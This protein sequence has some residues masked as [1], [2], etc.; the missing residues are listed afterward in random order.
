[1]R[2]PG[3]PMWLIHNP[4]DG[5][6]IDVVKMT[7]VLS[8]PASFATTPL[9][10]PAAYDFDRQFLAPKNPDSTDIQQD[11]D[12]DG[13][14]TNSS[15]NIDDRIL[16]ASEDNNIIVA[17]HS[18]QVGSAFLQSATV[19]APSMSNPNP[20][21]SGYTVGDTL[22]LVGGT[23]TTA[24]QLTVATLGPGGS[25]ATVTIANP[26]NYT[27][28]PNG[29]VTGGT[30][31][32]ATFSL[33]FKGELDVQ[34]YAID[35]SGA[36]PA[37]QL[38]GGVANVGRI[39]FGTNTYSFYPGIDINSSGQIGLSFMESDTVGGAVN[40]ATSG[41]VS[42]FVTAR[43]PGDAA[44][45]TEASVLVPAGT[46]SGDIV[47]RAGDFSGMNVDP[48]NGTFWGT[49]QFGIGS[50][51]DNVIANFTPDAT[52][53][54]TPP[55]PQT[56][57]EGASQS[58]SLGSFIDPNT[59]PWSVDVSWGDGTPDTVFTATAPGTIS[60]QSHTYGEEGP[61]TGTITVTNT[62]I[63]LFDSQPFTVTVTDPPVVQAS[64]VPVSAV[65]GASFGPVALAT[66]TDPGG[67][68]P[69]PSDPSGTL[70][71]HYS[72]VS[73]DWGDGTPLDTSSGS[74]S[75]SGSPG[76]TTDPFTVSGSHTYGEEGPY[77]VTVIVDHEGVDTT[78]TDT[79]SVSDPAVVATG[80]PV[81]ATACTA[82]TAVPI[83]TFIDPGGAEPNPS[84]PTPG[85]SNH[86][87]VDSIDWGD[88]TPLDTSSGSISYSGSPGSTTDPFTVSGSHTYET[89]G[90]FTITAIIDHEG[91]LTTVTTTAIVKDKLGL[92]LLDP[93]GSKSLMVSG[94]GNVDVTGDCGAVVVD[95]NNP[96][97]AVLVSGNGV[98]AAGDFDVTGGVSTS[99]H[100]VVPSP[101]D[102]EAPTAD[103]LGLVLPSPP[104]PTFG[105][106]HISGGTVTLPAGTYV[107]GISVSGNSTVTLSAGVYYMEGGGF[108]VSGGSVVTGTSGVVIINAPGRPSDSISVSGKGVLDLTAPGSGQPFQGVALFQDPSSSITISFT[109]QANVTITGVV[110]APAA[111]VSITGNA[112]VTINPGAGTA[113]LPPIFAAMIA[114]D[115]QVTGNGDL[116]I[117]ADDPPGQPAIALL[118]GSGPAGNIDAALANLGSGT[119]LNNAVFIDPLLI[120]NVASDL[121][122]DS[123]WSTLFPSTKRSKR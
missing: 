60:S 114:Y 118:Q 94:N 40:A 58:F 98:V 48:V 111:P 102:H 44:G 105:A 108:S 78:L 29:T 91:V 73:I 59:G 76:S 55:G 62:F 69:N 42:T 95:S 88:A 35:V 106:K 92:L 7:S 101:I 53:T 14:T 39:G 56:S 27:G 52:P 86:Y 117:N 68:E 25:V 113:T 82:L 31:T 41:F 87:K 110:Y 104:S 93:T 121:Q 70:N 77:T 33:D 103:P 9:T 50:T 13:D 90:T 34:W 51:P 11:D 43:E 61:Y 79:A 96:T 64:S 84:D 26:G 120:N 66:F 99:G 19:P 2:R 63:G 32:G 49:N 10:L 112:V 80:V 109:G 16:K 30:G 72:I 89:E 4:D 37:F 28:G 1:M 115:A 71:D 22:T 119:S 122:G 54:V 8:S 100:G 74:I 6:T 45:T 21:G 47:D 123:G 17:T 15:S 97:S 57:A 75:Y 83:A 38:V 24:A 36:T 3:D 85:I 5:S 67:A 81:F 20:G 18:V 65:E 107:G 46:G 116:T 12:D 23:F